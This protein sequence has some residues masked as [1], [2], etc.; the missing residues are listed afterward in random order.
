MPAGMPGT[1]PGQGRLF[2]EPTEP[3]PR[4]DPAHPVRTYT[5]THCMGGCVSGCICT[6]LSAYILVHKI[7]ACVKQSR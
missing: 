1:V 6:Y 4:S 7:R 5:H 2:V 3:R